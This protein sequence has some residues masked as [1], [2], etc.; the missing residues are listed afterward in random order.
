MTAGPEAA[1]GPSPVPA[2]PGGKRL[3]LFDGDCGWCSGWA[4]WLC[5]HDRDARFLL[6]PLAGETARRYLGAP[7]P[8][9]TMALVEP[10][11]ADGR[12]LLRSRAVLGVLTGLGWP[13]R[14]AGVLR[15]VPP[16]WGDRI[17][18]IVARRRHAFPAR[19]A[20]APSGLPPER[21]L[22]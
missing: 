2:P 10:L 13:W 11:G 1:R 21:L 3:L 15:I 7:V 18:G 8:A 5:R 16:R 14:A 22:P 20:C 12:V 9:D 6:A 17:Y 19:R 4:A